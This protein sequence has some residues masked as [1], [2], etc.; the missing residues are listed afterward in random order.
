[1]KKLS[2]ENGSIFNNLLK[3]SIGILTRG[4]ILYY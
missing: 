2:R 4:I 3:I 1:M